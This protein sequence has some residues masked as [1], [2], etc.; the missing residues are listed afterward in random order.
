MTSRQAHRRIKTL[1]RRAR[2]VEALAYDVRLVIADTHGSHTHLAASAKR[3]RD[4]LTLA[5][6]LTADLLCESGDLLLKDV[7]K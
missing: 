4:S 1:L 7:S 3:V 5:L 2:E 6:S